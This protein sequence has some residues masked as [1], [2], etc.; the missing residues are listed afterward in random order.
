V[1][2]HVCV[3]PFPLPLLVLCVKISVMNEEEQRLEEQILTTGQALEMLPS[4]AQNIGTLLH[5]TSP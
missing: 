3:R 4:A 5:V 2:Y 1:H